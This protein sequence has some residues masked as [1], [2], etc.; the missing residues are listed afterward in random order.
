M[1]CDEGEIEAIRRQERLVSLRFLI[2]WALY[3]LAF[4]M[5]AFAAGQLR[6]AST[7]KSPYAGYGALVYVGSESCAGCHAAEHRDWIGSQHKAAMQE[8]SEQTVLGDFGN[9]TFTKDGVES[10]FFQ[11][12]GKYWVR[13]DGPDGK[14][15]DFEIRYTFGVAPLQ[16]YL[17]E[18]PG[19]RLQALGIAWDARPK[20]EGGQRWYHLYPDRKL[21]A[22]DP[23]HWTGIDQ[24]WNYQ[25][26]YCH[27]TNLKKN[28]DPV[29]NT[30]KTSWS[31]I[32]VGCEACHGPGSGHIAWA[33][34]P[35]GRDGGAKGLA[36]GFHER[37][38][39]TWSVAADGK[40]FR[41][42]PRSTAT[43]INVCAKCHSRRQQFADDVQTPERLFDA[44]RPSHLQDGLYYADGQQRDEVYTYGSFVQSKMHAAGVTCSDCHNPHTGKLRQAGNAICT[45]CHAPERFDAASHHRHMPGSKGAECVACHMPTT[46]YMGIDERH[47]H[48]MRI[49]RPDR[50]ITLAT[51]NACNDCHTDKT[52]AWARDAIKGWFPTPKPGMLDF[53]VAF[54]LGDRGAAG[55]QEALRGIIQSAES[56]PIAVASALDRMVRFPSLATLANATQHLRHADPAVRSAALSVVAGADPQTRRQLLTPLLK[57]E[58]RTVRMDAARALAGPAEA[59]LSAEERTAFKAA[60]EEYVAAQL[61]NA[62][63]PEAH[64]NLGSL[65]RD[66]GQIEQAR[67]AFEKSIAID[68]TFVVAAISLADLLR[69]AGDESAAE[70]VLRK[71]L[72]SNANSG[73][74]QHALGLSLI[75]QKRTSEGVEQLTK[76]AESSP[77][78]PRFAYV[79]G[80]ALHDTGKQAE[81]ISALRN[82]VA[83]HPYDRDLLWVLASYEVQNGDQSAA[84]QRVQLLTELEPERHDYAEAFAS[85]KRQAR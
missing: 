58:A 5:A 30:F 4:G 19:G 84:L 39:I 18:L 61:F 51:P 74:I 11:R 60:L 36:V 37:R 20:T 62:E 22:G 47:D 63:R 50:S 8:A 78:E 79:L 16:Q 55:A 32:S 59:G 77:D 13:T 42:A 64:A 15:D 26:A 48:S 73:P 76:A 14:L 40:P 56:S 44:F 34:S 35:N 57:D 71:A 6:A 28:F 66:R 43:E 75:R 45:Q 10:T 82:A 2:L 21:S 81:A 7:D 72:S 25:C 33:S 38:G 80:V 23:L 85:L 69:E 3:A 52:A 27:S 41:S 54:D 46:T 65:H 29:G 12:D 1:N 31:E 53:A 9:V 83:R 70:A 49:P 24:N 17:I 67:A 68:A